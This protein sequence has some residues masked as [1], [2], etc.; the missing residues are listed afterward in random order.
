LVGG[1]AELASRLSGVLSSHGYIIEHISEQPVE[2]GR[3]RKPTAIVLSAVETGM[4]GLDVLISAR[5]AVP[6]IPAVV[7]V[8]PDQVRI[9]ID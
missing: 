9:A 8:A 3:D 4:P 5:K 6:P 1:D 2:F 7:L